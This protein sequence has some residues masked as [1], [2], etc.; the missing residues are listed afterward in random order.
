MEKV[1]HIVVC[2]MG[3]SGLPGYA[4]DSWAL[5]EG[6]PFRVTVWNSYD[7]PKIQNTKTPVF[8]V[9]YSGN[10]EETISNFLEARRRG[11]PVTVITAGGKL[12]ALARRYRVPV[13]PVPPGLPPRSALGYL[14]GAILEALAKQKAVRI[15]A[16][17]RRAFHRFD[18][19]KRIPVGA[20]LARGL[21]KRVPLIYTGRNWYA[22][23]HI[24]KIALN[25]TAKIPAFSYT[26]PEAN[27]NEMEG[28]AEKP[29]A[30]NRNFH[31]LFIGVAGDHPRIKKRMRLSKRVW[32][33][34]GVPVTEI[35]LPR[36][37]FWSVL[38]RGVELGYSAAREIARLRGV[39]PD[40][41]KAIEAFKKEMTRP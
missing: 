36:G 9:S 22:L 40:A 19:T 1:T 21:A 34:A 41:T 18:P 12:A 15:S 7:F 33:R 37:E 14:T 28:F 3:G 25:E 24:W 10:T 26:I 20:R 27:H 29:F 35:T 4:L 17:G 30:A 11:H 16:K 5:V 8:C 2:G 39:D 38:F 31:A 6:L 23:G 32:V 13:I